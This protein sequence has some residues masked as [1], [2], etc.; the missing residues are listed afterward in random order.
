MPGLTGTG[1]ASSRGGSELVPRGSRRR[2]VT[3]RFLHPNR[4]YC[5][6]D[7]SAFHWRPGTVCLLHPGNENADAVQTCV[8]LSSVFKHTME[9]SLSGNIPSV[10]KLLLIETSP[11]SEVHKHQCEW[12]SSARVFYYF[13]LGVK[14]PPPHGSSGSVPRACTTS[15]KY[16]P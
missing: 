1:L 2:R 11:G 7:L 13:V 12:Y 5:S 9:I 15:E 8:Q 6:H 4:R 10:T 16:H 3:R 14:L